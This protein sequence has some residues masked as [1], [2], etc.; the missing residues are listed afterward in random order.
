MKR[1]PSRKTSK[2][3]N[4]RNGV[5][6]T[7]APHIQNPTSF[8]HDS[9]YDYYHEKYQVPDHG[10]IEAEN[11]YLLEQVQWLRGENELLKGEMNS[12]KISWRKL[13]VKEDTL[14]KSLKNSNSARQKEKK[15]LQNELKVLK[16]SFLA[17]EKE[18]DKEILEL[19]QELHQ[20]INQIEVFYK[21]EMDSIK[22]E[23]DNLNKNVEEQCEISKKLLEEAEKERSGLQDK[24]IKLD[25]VEKEKMKMKTEVDY[26]KH[27]IDELKNEKDA[28]SKKVKELE[29]RCEFLKRIFDES[30]REKNVIKKEKNGISEWCAN[31][32][33]NETILKNHHRN[34]LLDC[35]AQFQYQKN[36]QDQYIFVLNQEKSDLQEKLRI[37]SEANHKHENQLKEQFFVD[38][39]AYRKEHEENQKKI[40]SLDKQ[41]HDKEKESIEYKSR[42]E[43]LENKFQ[44]V[45]LCYICQSV[46]S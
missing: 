3:R 10:A 6:N 26:L 20:N 34:E 14:K 5:R 12:I 45:E 35:Q 9:Y 46:N 32:K 15:K 43:E 44:S 37:V 1:K 17:M 33:H 2:K 39:Q 24:T 42:V 18:K 25:E 11:K 36:T 27:Y 38:I 13:D 16:E 40:E 4:K 22:N 31:L 8:S 23:N 21:P 19:K 29:Q 41:L 30:E 7:P 28:T